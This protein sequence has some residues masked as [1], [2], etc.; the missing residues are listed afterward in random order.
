MLVSIVT[1]VFNRLDR[2]REF[3]R[4]LEQ[5]PPPEPWEIIWVDDGS[6]DGTCEWL[7]TL[8]APRHRVIFNTGNLGYAVANNLGTRAAAG[9]ILGLLNNDLILTPGWFGPMAAILRRSTAAGLVGNVQLNAATG[10]VDHSGIYYY[11]RGKPTH[12]R[13]LPTVPPDGGRPVL[14]A[15]GACLLVTRERFGQL[16]GFDEMFRNGCEDVDLCLRARAAGAQNYVALDSVVRHHVSSSP[17]RSLH[18]QRNAYLLMRRWRA[19]IPGLAAESWGEVALRDRWE[20][21]LTGWPWLRA[22]LLR[23]RRPEQTCPVWMHRATTRFVTRQLTAWER[24]FPDV[25][26][27]DRSRD[28]VHP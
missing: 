24:M 1:A 4:S 12:D 5:H 15:T 20:D 25:R 9:E 21:K 13:T 17:G 26:T 3:W 22:R 10:A 11:A 7:R 16:G 23:R 28:P 14:A 19:E 6:T 27:G 8:P 2:T 18:N